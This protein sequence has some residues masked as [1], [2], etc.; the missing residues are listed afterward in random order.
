M[1]R[2]LAHSHRKLLT[3]GIVGLLNTAIDVGIFSFLQLGVK[4]P[5]VA[6]NIISTATA[7]MVSFLLNSRFTFKTDSSPRKRLVPYIAVTLIGLWVLQ[8]LVILT[9]RPVLMDLKAITLVSGHAIILAKLA[10]VA[11]SMVWNFVLYNNVVFKDS[12]SST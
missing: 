9:L 7:L 6:A 10:S 1:I 4:L 12:K 2:K 3:F 8:P 5:I 11:V